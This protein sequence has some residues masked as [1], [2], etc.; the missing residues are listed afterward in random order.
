LTEGLNARLYE[1]IVAELALELVGGNR[2]FVA[3][4]VQDRQVVQVFE[5]LLVLAQGQH[6]GDTFAVLVDATN[7]NGGGARPSGAFAVMFRDSRALVR[8][9]PRRR[10]LPGFR[11]SVLPQPAVE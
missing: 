4:L 5:Q 7:V 1:A 9:A 3:A 6:H 8:A 11:R 2:L 10:S